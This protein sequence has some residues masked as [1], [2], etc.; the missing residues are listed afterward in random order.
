MSITTC[1][2]PNI[3]AL[4]SSHYSPRAHQ[5]VTVNPLSSFL[6]I[7]TKI[8]ITTITARKTNVLGQLPQQPNL[9]EAFLSMEGSR[10]CL[11]SA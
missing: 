9:M 1:F 7:S 8:T 4:L 6:L 2:I 11:V 3:N 10:H 5:K